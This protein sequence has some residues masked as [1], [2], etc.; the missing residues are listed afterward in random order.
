MVE[1]DGK[2]YSGTVEKSQWWL[3]CQPQPHPT[4]IASCC[5]PY[6]M[7]GLTWCKVEPS[8][9]G[10]S[11]L[12]WEFMPDPKA[13]IHGMSSSQRNGLIQEL[14]PMWSL[15]LRW[16]LA[17][18]TKPFSCNLNSR[19]IGDTKPKG[20]AEMG[21]C[22]ERSKKVLSTWQWEPQQSRSNGV[23]KRNTGSIRQHERRKQRQN[24]AESP[25]WQSIRKGATDAYCWSHV[26]KNRWLEVYYI[27]TDIPAP[28]GSC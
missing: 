27:L 20:W 16:W 12:K 26:K 24:V 4:C 3:E 22:P 18:Q 13:A 17:N 2:Q 25:Y 9:P 5:R 28:P 11:R 23:E 1:L 21:R 7:H 15:Y 6:F 10:Y 14:C 8:F 19:P